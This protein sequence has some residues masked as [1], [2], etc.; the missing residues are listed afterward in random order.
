[1]LIVGAGQS[2][3]V[4]AAA[5]RREVVARVAVV[6]RAGPGQTGPWRTFARMAELRTTKELVGTELGVQSLSLRR[7]Y[8]TRYGAAAW[9]A[10]E[11]VP[12]TDWHD[13]LEWCCNVLALDVAH[14]VE[15]QDVHSEGELMAVAVRRVF[16][17]SGASYVS[18]GPQSTSISGHKHA[19]PRL[20]RGVTRRLFLDQ[21]D[22]VVPDVLAV[23][24]LDLP[25][26]EDFEASLRAE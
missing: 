5:L 19:L 15:V 3:L 13:Y 6:D 21:A 10:I 4:I 2:W 1:M 11:R 16:D 18:L 22:T 7:G 8:E 17:F 9:D 12:R 24:T 14:G 26:G 25:I 20:V 23:D